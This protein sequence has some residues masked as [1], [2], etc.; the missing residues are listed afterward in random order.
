MHCIAKTLQLVHNT[1]SVKLIEIAGQ[2]H[3]KTGVSCAKQLIEEF[4]AEYSN[5]EDTLC[6]DEGVAGIES[7]RESDITLLE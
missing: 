3:A 1:V 6:T 4:G 5:T 2:R 7:S